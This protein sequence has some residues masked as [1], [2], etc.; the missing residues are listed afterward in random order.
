MRYFIRCLLIMIIVWVTGADA[1][2]ANEKIKIIA[3]FSIL[4]DI[5]ENIG[6]DRVEIDS[7]VGP[8]Q[9]AHSF[10]PSPTDVV[11]IENAMLIIINGLGFEG[12]LERMMTSSRTLPKIVVASDGIA[13]LHADDAASTNIQHPNALDPHAWQDAANARIYAK[14]IMRAL[15]TVDAEHRDIYVANFERFDAE[16]SKLDAHIRNEIAT[17]PVQRRK[18]VTTHDAFGYFEKA[19]GLEIIA[20]LGVAPEAQPSAKDVAR[21]I[22]QIRTDSIPA[23]FLET[24]IDSRLAEQISSESGA[25]LGGKL[26]SDALSAKNGPAGS[27]IAMM[28]TNIRELKHALAQ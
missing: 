5:A 19:Y 11:H 14:N 7:L 21:I 8:G 9:D 24:M 12:W 25:K 2:M 10:D 28:E 22:R 15:V 16:L 18:L 17:I 27:Y 26:Y 1:V 4:A 6:G 20:P 23:I 3:S 13:P